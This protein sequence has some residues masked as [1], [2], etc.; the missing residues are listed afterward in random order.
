MVVKVNDLRVAAELGVVGKDP[1]GAVAYK[2][3]AQE[4]LTRLLDVTVNIGRT[5]KVTPT[6]RLEPVFLSGVTV[7]NASLHNYDLIEKLDIRLGDTVIIKRSGEVIPYVIG[8]VIT[9]RTGDE[10][11]IRPPATCPFSGDPLVQPEGAVDTFCPNPHCPERVFRQ[12]EFFVSRGALDIEGMGPQTVKT[13]IERGLI[14]DE[15]DI[16]T[17]KADDLLALEGFAQKKVDNLLAAIDAARGRPLAQFLAALGIDGVG[18]TVAGV[19]A[20]HFG[21]IDRLSAATPDDIVA[22]EGVGPIIA[23]NVHT[24]FADPFNQDLLAK[25]R[26]AGVTMQA[27]ARALTSSTLAGLTFV[28]TGT[29]PTLTR[30]EA[31]ALIE[32]HGGR[33]VG[34]VSKKTSYVIV[35]DS[36]GSKADKAAK[37]GITILDETG[38]QRLIESET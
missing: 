32:A 25:F 23:A 18:S 31:T 38:L 17:L 5:G 1:R 10:Q 11:P 2:F 16:F 27:G 7:V 6:A 15:A 28:L 9:L 37:F 35:G 30:D 8:P 22:V 20:A 13:L 12:V 4:A 26:A 36:P 34:S 19:L 33:V 24:W 21:S 14:A 3:P 29:L